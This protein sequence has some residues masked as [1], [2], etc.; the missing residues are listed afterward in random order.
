[1]SHLCYGQENKI[2]DSVGFERKSS[3][4]GMDN[5]IGSGSER[6]RH[7]HTYN[8]MKSLLLACQP[9]MMDF[10]QVFFCVVTRLMYGV[11]AYPVQMSILSL[12]VVVPQAR[13]WTGYNLFLIF[14]ELYSG[15][16]GSGMQLALFLI[17]F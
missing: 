3:G 13:V 2:L 12:P 16:T 6:V 7:T 15:R 9:H 11:M 17:I 8:G 10:V 4:V 5:N 1:M 14:P